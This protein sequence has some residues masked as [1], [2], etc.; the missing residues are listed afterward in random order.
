MVMA[1]PGMPESHIRVLVQF[2]ANLLLIQFQL[3]GKQWRMTQ[4]KELLPPRWRPSCSSWL[5]ASAWSTPTSVVIWRLTSRWNISLLTPISLLFNQ[6]FKRE[7]QILGCLG[8]GPKA[9]HGTS[10]I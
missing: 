2:V 9:N 8:L 7:T 10:A 1:P 3:P 6:I 5:L 4:V